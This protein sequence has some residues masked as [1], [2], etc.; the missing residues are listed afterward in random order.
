MAS[1]ENAT[2]RIYRGGCFGDEASYARSANREADGPRFAD[3]DVGV[4]PA[5]AVTP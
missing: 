4:R 1:G 3:D 2:E 5:R